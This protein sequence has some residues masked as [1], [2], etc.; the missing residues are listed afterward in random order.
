MTG[1]DYLVFTILR[2][3]SFGPK[4]NTKLTVDHPPTYRKLFEGFQAQQEAKIWYVGFSQSKQL[5]PTVLTP[6]L[7]KFFLDLKFCWSKTNFGPKFFQNQNVWPK[8][9]FESKKNFDRK[10][11]WSKNFFVR[12]PIWVRKNFVLKKFWSEKKCWVQKKT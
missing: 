1:L 9:K 11:F 12:K 3:Q 4:Q 6:P 8:K 2:N 5:G 7:S 10:K